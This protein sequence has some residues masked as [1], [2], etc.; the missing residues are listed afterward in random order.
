M[1]IQKKGYNIA[2]VV[3]GVEL[4]VG[5]STSVGTKQD[6]DELRELVANSGLCW[7]KSTVIRNGDYMNFDGVVAC[8]LCQNGFE[9]HTITYASNEVTGGSPIIFGGQFYDDN[10]TVKCHVTAVTVSDPTVA[11]TRKSTSK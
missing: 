4:V 2:E 5:E 8:N 9:F 7:V 3:T 6:L 10:G 1:N 11:S